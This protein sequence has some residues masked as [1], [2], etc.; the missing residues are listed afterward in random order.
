M[1]PLRWTCKST[2]QLAAL[3]TAQ[4]RPLS[5][6]VVGELLHSLGYSLQANAK[7]VEGTQHADRDAQFRHINARVKYHLGRGFPVVSVDTSVLTVLRP[8]SGSTTSSSP[9]WAGLS[10]T[11]STA[12]ARTPA[13]T[14]WASTT[15][16]PH[17]P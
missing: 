15:T 11:G 1:S 9:N 2:R 13:G 7:M 5:H 8:A 3:L 17:S 16:P 14:A 4:G 12:S 6:R 10:P